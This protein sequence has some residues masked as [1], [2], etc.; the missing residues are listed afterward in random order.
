[1]GS[2]K[3]DIAYPWSISCMFMVGSMIVQTIDQVWEIY[4]LQSSNVEGHDG[5][6]TA[7]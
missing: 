3:V 6:Q 5:G 1:M 7:S 4:V 2:A